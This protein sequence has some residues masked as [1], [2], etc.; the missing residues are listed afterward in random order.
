LVNFQEIGPKYA[1]VLHGMANTAG[2]IAGMVGT[3]ATGAVLEATGGNWSA[4]LYITAVV[5][6][7]GAATWLTMSTGERVFD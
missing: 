7:L 5:Y 4:V 6:A 2:S 1:G 3:Y